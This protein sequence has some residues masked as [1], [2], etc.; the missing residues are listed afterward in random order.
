MRW[1]SDDPPRGWLARALVA[2][3]ALSLVAAPF[4]FPGVKTLGVAE[5]IAVMA[6]LAASYDV[7]LGY[8]GIVSFAH[9][10]FFGCGAYGVGL[11]LYALGPGWGAIALGL[12]GGMALAALIALALGAFSLRVQAIFFA[13][14]TLAVAYAFNVLAS[15]WTDFTGGEDGRTFRVPEI[16]R[17]GAHAFGTTGRTLVYYLVLAGAAATFLV[18]LRVVNSPFGRVLQAIRENPLRAEALGYRIVIHRTLAVLVSA[19]AA[20]FVGGLDA[21]WL[22][23]VGPDTA[24]S[25]SIQIDVLV[26][27]VLGGRGTLYGAVVGAAV[28]VIAETYLRAL[29]AGAASATAGWPLLPGL[30]HPDRW[31][32][33]LG[34]LFILAVRFAPRGIVGELARREKGG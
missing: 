9:V 31:L 34:L 13:M 32:L 21:L 25:F 12:A 17:P 11:A 6:A 33:W 15:Q 20:A 14:V 8:T 2:L 3:T 19:L 27:V 10:M 5:K 30:L 1:L 26:I 7:L 4:V 28:F 24:L 23:Y 22:R 18:L 16:L 29:I